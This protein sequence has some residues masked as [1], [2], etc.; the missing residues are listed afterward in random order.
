MHKM[1]FCVALLESHDQQNGYDKIA[2]YICIFLFF[3]VQTV[4]AAVETLVY[5]C[6]CDVM[7]V[8]YVTI[9][10]CTCS[11]TCVAIHMFCV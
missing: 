3:I 9:C 10:V 4:Y 5:V 7:I 2:A 6:V 8:E 1:L 11:Y